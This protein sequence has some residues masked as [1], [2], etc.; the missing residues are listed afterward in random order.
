MSNVTSLRGT[1]PVAVVPTGSAYRILP[2]RLVTFAGHIRAGVVSRAT[3][4]AAAP[5]AAKQAA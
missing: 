3:P 4:V 5:V 1:R 2:G